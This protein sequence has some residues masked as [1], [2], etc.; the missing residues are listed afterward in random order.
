MQYLR[1]QEEIES[2]CNINGI[3]ELSTT[4]ISEYINTK[5]DLTPLGYIQSIQENTISVFMKRGG[6][7]EP[8]N[9]FKA[10]LEIIGF[11]VNSRAY[12]DGVHTNVHNG[13]IV[14]LF[15][16]MTDGIITEIIA[17]N[18]GGYFESVGQFADR[19]NSKSVDFWF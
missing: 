16:K 3:K 13:K 2:F 8:E 14:Q 17:L 19:S 18:N 5:L 1:N 4:A 9:K 7:R 15:G 6:H 11:L 10:S 12:L